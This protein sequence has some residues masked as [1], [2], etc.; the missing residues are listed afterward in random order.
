MPTLV[1][2][3]ERSYI[4]GPPL[5]G[6]LLWMLWQDQMQVAE[7]VPEVAFAQGLGVGD[8]EMFL[9][10][11]G[12]QRLWQGDV[13]TGW[14]L[15]CQGF[16][17][18]EMGGARFVQAGQHGVD[19]MDAALRRDDQ[20]RPAFAR[21]RYPLLVGDS[22]QRAHDGGADGDDASA[23]YPCLIHESRR[24]HRH[25]VILFIGWFVRFEAGDAGM[26]Q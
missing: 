3:C 4:V 16:E 23:R 5:A 17:H 12:E 18:G 9:P 10:G 8:F 22:F 13:C 14:R 6:G 11:A 15:P 20:S 7:F 26:Q 1:E 21:M 24:L 25:A 2:P 19:G